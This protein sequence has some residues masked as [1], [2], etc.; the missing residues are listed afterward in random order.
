MASLAWWTTLKRVGYDQIFGLVVMF[1]T[2][3][4]SAAAASSFLP[5]SILDY[6]LADG[7]VPPVH[8]P[9]TESEETS[10]SITVAERSHGATNCVI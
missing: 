3:L 5:A 8:E 9:Y 7:T 10:K 6:L 2:I 4:G 1:M